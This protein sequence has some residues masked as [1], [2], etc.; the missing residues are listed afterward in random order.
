[1]P[2]PTLIT[3]LSTTAV[4]NYPSGSDSPATLDDVQRAHGA[5][6]AQIR[7]GTVAIA[8]T[9][10]TGTASAL[11]IGGNAATA[12]NATNVTGTI[13]SAATATTQTVGDNSTKVATTAY[14]ATEIAANPGIPAGT[15]IHV[16][17][18][19]APTGYIKANGALV[20]RT[21]YA[22]LFA[23]IGTVYGVGDGSTTFALPDL[24]GEFVR[25]WDDARGI[26]SGRA[27]GTAQADELE[28]HTHGI[29]YSDVVNASGG[30]YPSRVA[31]NA[32][33]QSTATGGTETRPRNIALLACIKT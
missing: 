26:D 17:M 32:A 20:S 1:M 27:I 3:E 29:G 28:S 23:A 25:G 30:I 9:G 15:V 14:V 22:T 16:A 21:T 8:G 18:S 6:I 5:F 31:A 10:L 12:T 33:I 13:A 19:T 4:S 11:S 7:D 24:R 2:V